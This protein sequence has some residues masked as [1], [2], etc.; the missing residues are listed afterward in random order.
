[1]AGNKDD[2]KKS[3]VKKPVKDSGCGSEIMIVTGTPGTGKTTY[4]KKLAKDKGYKYVD[5]NDVMEEENLSEGYDMERKT[6]IV[7]ENKLAKVLER[8]IKEARKE[9]SGLVIDSHLSHHISPELAD[10][11]I[12]T[13]CGLKELEK[14][15]KEKGYNKAKIEENIQSEI[16]DIC[17]NE[18]MEAGH[19][20]ITIRTD[21]RRYETECD[22]RS[23]KEEK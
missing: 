22:Y 8:I 20:V 18:A 5:V 23:N 14:R 2:A 17:L 7:D 15:L 16:F 6:R 3:S 9:G 21:N 11:C 10:L 12:V 1:M 13:K 19:A 4:A